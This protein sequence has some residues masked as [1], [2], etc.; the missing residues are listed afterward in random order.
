MN[1]IEKDNIMDKRYIKLEYS[2]NEKP[3][4]KVDNVYLHSRFYPCMEAE[5]FA[6]GNRSIFEN[7]DIV[8]VYGLALGYHI[9]EL[10]KRILPDCR[11]FIFDVDTEIYDIGKK[12]GCYNSIFKD[13][14]VKLYIGIDSLK[15]MSKIEN[16]DNIIVYNPSLRV[17]P[18]DYEKVKYIF[19]NFTIA[20]IGIEKSRD[21]MKLNYDHNIKEAVF[22]MRDFFK[23]YVFENKPVITAAAGPSLD[24]NLNKLK[25]LNGKVKIFCVGSALRT[26]MKNGIVPDMICIMDCKQ[27]VAN[28]LR[29]YENLDVPLCFLSTASRWAVS[30]Y[31]G[32]RYIFYNDENPAGDIVVNTAK[33]VAVPTIDIAVKGGASEVILV[34]QDLAFLDNRT[35]T[36][37]FNETYSMNDEVEGQSKMY[38]K[39]EGVNGE[40]LNT[41][42]EYLNF[43]HSIELEIEKNPQVKFINCSSGAK[44]KGASYIKLS[45]WITKNIR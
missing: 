21:I 5:R 43:K 24:Y 19:K 12:L 40:V 41:R 6:D 31:S 10:L 7:K 8:V 42:Y 9:V 25:K 23:K 16:L 15:Y 22:T 18:A 20:R 35:H 39:V 37:S 1:N 17:L 26:L 38:R 2:R 4:L 28:Q 30:K 34:G 14:R 29:D 11:L 13:K 44:I 45:E 27:V 33:T 32:P 3:V 36:S